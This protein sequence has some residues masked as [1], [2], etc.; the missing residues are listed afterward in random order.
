MSE[1]K[2]VLVTGAAG[3]L[4]I[5]PQGCFAKIAPTLAKPTF[6]DSSPAD[7]GRLCKRSGDF[8]DPDRQ[9][10]AVAPRKK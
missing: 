7:E 5:V 3:S 9:D 10:W 8:P 6:V 4:A 1:V 2:T